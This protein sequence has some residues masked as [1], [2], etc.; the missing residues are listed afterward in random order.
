M[1]DLNAAFPE[2]HKNQP[3][4]D[5]LR[6]VSERLLPNITFK[7]SIKASNPLS[8]EETRGASLGIFKV[9]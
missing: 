1:T 9:N 5:D 3:D 6:I 8:A 7:T 4:N 2:F